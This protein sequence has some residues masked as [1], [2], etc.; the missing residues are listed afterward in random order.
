MLFH[1]LPFLLLFLP[2]AIAAYYLFADSR[3]VRIWILIVASVV[4]YGY[5]DLR[6]VPLL[7]G[8]VILNWLLAAAFC[9]FPRWPLVSVGVALNLLILGIFKY[10]DF[11]ADSLAAFAGTQHQPWSIVLPLGISFFT[12]QQI[13]YLID[14]RRHGGPLYRFEEY[15]LYVTFFPQLI[16]GPIVRHNEIIFQYAAS[17]IRAG[18][19]ERLSRG[20]ALFVI[21]LAKKA[22]IA[23]H[24]AAIA[25]PLFAAAGGGEALSFGAAWA[26]AGAFTFQI[27]FDFSG[28]S[29]MAIGLGL[30]F[31]LSLPVNFNAPYRAISIRDFWRRWHMTLSRFLRDYLYIPLGGN[32]H[33]LAHQIGAILIT[34]LLGGLWHG[35]AWTFVAWGGLHGAALTIDHLWEKTGARIPVALSWGATLL[36]VVFAWVLFRAGT[37]AEASSILASM[38]GANGFSLAIAGVKG[39]WLVPLAAAIALLGPTSQ[40]ATLDLLAPR[41][42][43]AVGL[44]MALVLVLLD[45]GGGDSAEFIYFQ[46]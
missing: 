21:G 13:S 34:M 29:D 6:L 23:D 17:P 38:V 27:Y 18:L 25:D 2:A 28:Y 46:F 22:G 8:S 15:A 11:F 7:V 45:A 4:F 19:E 24:M 16:A 35:A 26:A 31:G 3:R 37:F 20:L 10:A 5:W 30:L 14:L 33:G 43:I 41:R 40:K 9:R 44:A 39:L 1:S 36:F 12:F 42:A 32:R